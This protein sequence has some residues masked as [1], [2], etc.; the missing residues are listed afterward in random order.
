[1]VKSV[2][3]VELRVVVAEV[4]AVAADALLVENQLQKLG[5]QLVSALARLHVHNL[6]RQKAW[7]REH[8]GEIGRGGAEKRKKLRLKVGQEKPKIPVAR[9]RVSREPT[10]DRSVFIT[11]TSRAVSAVQS[12]QGLGGRGREI[13]VLATFPL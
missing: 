1:V 11:S 6:A 8:A 10:G 12:A 5:A 2:G 7:R 9:A 3:A 13:F 4:L